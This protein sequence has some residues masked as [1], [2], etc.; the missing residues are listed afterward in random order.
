MRIVDH[1]Q[2]AV[3]VREIANFLQRRDAAIHREHTVGRDEACAAILRLLQVLFEL[4][5]ISI[6]VAQSTRFAQPDAIDDAGVVERVGDDGILFAEHGFEQA[7]VG[8]PTGGIQDGVLGSEEARQRGL[9]LLVHG[10][11]AADEAH[12]GHAITEPVEGAVRSLADRRVIRE[13]QV[14]VSAQVDD[15]RVIGADLPGLRACDHAFG[16]E[17]ALLAQLV[18]LHVESLVEGV[19]HASP[20]KGQERGIGR[21]YTGPR[22]DKCARK[23]SRRGQ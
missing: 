7:T 14:I 6:R 4:R 3:L 9:E 20:G 11:R 8:I 18:E 17:Q 23:R 13:S 19:V 2:R 15:V 1:D 16:F 12:R 22:H 10:L 21:N 5:E